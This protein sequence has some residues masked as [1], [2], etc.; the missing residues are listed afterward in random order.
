MTLNEKISCYKPDTVRFLPEKFTTMF[1][2]FDSKEFAKI[3]ATR[4][5]KVPMALV[6]SVAKA[7]RNLV[8][9]RGS[10]L[11]PLDAHAGS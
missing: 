10:S 2:K 9:V 11:T 1:F 6:F 7:R 5:D 3:E 4:T 8:N